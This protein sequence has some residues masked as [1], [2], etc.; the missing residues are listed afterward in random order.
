MRH[1]HSRLE[2]DQL[3]TAVW[4]TR[5]HCDS[6]SGR[7]LTRERMRLSDSGFVAQVDTFYSGQAGF[8]YVSKC[9]LNGSV[10]SQPGQAHSLDV[11]HEEVHS[12]ARAPTA[13]V[14]IIDYDALKRELAS[15]QPPPPPSVDGVITVKITLILILT[16]GPSRRAH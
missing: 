7:S 10:T 15:R 9:L 11:S 2:M 5:V 8:V 16:S 4:L 12:S 1:D 13:T 6:R 14:H 3:T